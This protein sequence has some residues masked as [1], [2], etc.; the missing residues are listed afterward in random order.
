MS[1][2]SGSNEI[3]KGQVCVQYIRCGKPGCRC[4]DGKLHGPYHYRIWREGDKVHKV[5]V[6]QSEVEAV[7]AA[8]RA[9]QGYSEQLRGLKLQRLALTKGVSRAWRQA[10]HFLPMA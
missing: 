1:S 5:Y 6:R 2:L 7:Q 3:L 9:Y 4:V 8:C 10:K